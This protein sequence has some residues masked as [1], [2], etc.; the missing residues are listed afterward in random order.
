MAEEPSREESE[1]VY[2]GKTAPHEF[3]DTQALPSL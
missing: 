3:Y 2:E 1:K